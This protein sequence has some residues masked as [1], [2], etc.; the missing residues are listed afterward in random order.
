[1]VAERTLEQGFPS[2]QLRGVAHGYVRGPHNGARVAF[3][4]NVMEIGC[5]AIA[6]IDHRVQA[7]SL[8][9]R[10]RLDETRLKRQMFAADAAAENARD[11]DPVAGLSA[12]AANRTA[13]GRLPNQRDA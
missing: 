8:V 11:H 6:D 1:A 5:Q 9:K 10:N 2:R 7:N 12:A 4:E 13:P 3:V